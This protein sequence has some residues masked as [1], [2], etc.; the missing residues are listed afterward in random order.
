LDREKRIGLP[1]LALAR[2][3]EFGG[4]GELLAGPQTRTS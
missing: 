2:A 4:G 1:V 3:L